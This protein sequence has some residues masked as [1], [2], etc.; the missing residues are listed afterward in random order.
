MYNL[1]K[2]FGAGVLIL[3]LS[4]SKD[5]EC[6]SPIKEEI[7]QIFYHV[8]QYFE[9]VNSYTP[10]VVADLT[11]IVIALDAYKKN[12]GSFPVSSDNG[13]GWDGLHTKWGESRE[14]WIAGL[15]PEYI[16][17]LP[18]D[19]RLHSLQS[20]QYTYRS[21]GVDYKLISRNPSNCE[22]IERLSPKLIDKTRGNCNAVGFWTSSA[23]KW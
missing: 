6:K 19:P 7:N 17:R 14:D 16:D 9:P 15:T 18:R 11:R 20:S 1:A 3:L 8:P 21:D 10:V 22:R 5:P 13:A 23:S 12:K 4:C 2:F